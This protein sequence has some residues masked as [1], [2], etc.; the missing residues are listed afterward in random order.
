MKERILGQILALIPLLVMPALIGYALDRRLGTAPWATLVLSF[1][2]ALLA[3]V[4]ATRLT[5]NRYDAIAP[6][7]EREED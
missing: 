2:G 1:S 7:G 3:T 4:I 6:R 5:L